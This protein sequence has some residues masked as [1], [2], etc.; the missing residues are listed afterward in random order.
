MVELERRVES[1]CHEAWDQMVGVA[2]ARAE[3]QRAEERVIVDEQ[4]LEAARAH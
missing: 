2:V 1:A 4:E 3:G